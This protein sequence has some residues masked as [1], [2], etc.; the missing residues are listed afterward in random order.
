MKYAFVVML[1]LAFSGC[2]NRMFYYPDRVIRQTPAA[3][4][5]RFEAVTFP[6]TDG[7]HLTGWW[8]P[9]RTDTPKGTV[10]HFHGNAE[11]ISTHVQFAEW[12]P[13]AGYHLFVFDYRGYGRSAGTPT[14]AGL[15]RDGIAALQYAAGRP[16]T[17]P[18]TLFVWGQS[19]GGTVALQALA[20]T[21][22]PVRA[23]LIDS[24]FYSHAS[25]ASE[26]MRELPIYLQWLRLLRPLWVTGG[27]DAHQAL[28]DLPPELPIAFLHG[29]HDRVIPAHHSRELHKIAPNPRHLWI[30]PGA[31]HCDA[32]LR[33]PDLVR[34]KILTFFAHPDPEA[35]E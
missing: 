23:V 31:G 16:E 32:V 13:A 3:R 22:I 1:C 6:A 18:E 27:M 26:K 2:A 5:H 17:Q 10:I 19:L 33:F 24:T 25:I 34:P 35:A 8:L 15:V 21:E 4:G 20:R 9:A 30:I 14:R 11:N 12:L 29:E 7:T 28:R